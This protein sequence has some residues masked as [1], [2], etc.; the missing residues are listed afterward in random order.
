M[1]RA[2]REHLRDF[3][4]IVALLVLGL[5][6]AGLI[7][8][9]QHAVLPSW[10][11]FVGSSR[12]DIEAEISSAQA[13]TPGQG[14]T[15]DIAG[16]KIGDVTSVA[17]ESGRAVITMGIEPKYAPLIHSDAS[18]L[19]RPRTGLQDMAVE[20]NP[21]SG[22]KPGIKE[23]ATIP[24]ARSLPPVQSDQ[25]L[26]T[27]DADTRAYLQLLLGGGAQG[28]RG[29][30][31]SLSA[32]LRRLDPLAVDLARLN[33]ALASR[34]ANL[35]RVIH[36][37]GLLSQELA[38]HDRELADFV[39]SSSSVFGTFAREQGALRRTISELPS[40]LRATRGALA[41]GNRLALTLR[42]ALTRLLPQ[43]RALGPALRATRPL[44]RDTTGPIRD[45]IRP[46]T[47]QVQPVVRHLAQGA[48]PLA[49]A[50]AGLRGGFQNL[51]QLLNGLAY[52]PPGPQ[53]GFL[54]WLAWLNHDTN[55]TF[56]IQ[57]AG[58][59][60]QRG[61][62]LLSCQTATVLEGLLAIR[63]ELKTIRDLTNPPRA[64]EITA[65]GGCAP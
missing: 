25:I 54:F 64:S 9:S 46:F 2:I 26:A 65:A 61:I 23:G 6:T 16:I 56:S 18:V 37:F 52:N 5:V 62:V 41:S 58:G 38:R 43:A 3:A 29:N 30:T 24:E 39:T 55:S 59:P 20:L 32:D 50:T 12:F 13:V 17:L 36:N 15:V 10:V 31:R 63:P 22:S 51:N 8:V 49:K 11:P 35:A 1:R 40:T 53:E 34:R 33:G 42:P 27:L 7:V 45:Q 28:L 19:L 21:G 47:R 44:F 57:D 14:Q 48:A 60:D 4:A